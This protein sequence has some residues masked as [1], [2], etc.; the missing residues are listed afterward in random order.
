MKKSL[1]LEYEEW[2]KYE[3]KILIIE[4]NA[5]GNVAGS[6]INGVACNYKDIRGFIVDE[7]KSKSKWF[8]SLYWYN[9][10]CWLDDEGLMYF[11]W[12]Y[13]KHLKFSL[14]SKDTVSLLH[15]NES[16]SYI[17]EIVNA[18]NEGNNITIPL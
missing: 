4:S 8:K 18:T 2:L 15:N 16:K 9:R 17:I 12:T 13:D 5:L 11:H 10:T 14:G 1:P 3:G 7:F 6:Q